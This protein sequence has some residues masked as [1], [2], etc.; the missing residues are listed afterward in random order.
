MQPL[1]HTG[2]LAVA[3]KSAAYSI[4]D[5]VVLNVNGGK[6]IHRIVAGSD[7]SG[8]RTKGDNRK[9]V[10]PWVAQTHQIYGKYWRGFTGVGAALAW[11][12]QRPYEFAGIL[13]LLAVLPYVPTRRRRL[14]AGLA[15]ALELSVKE[16]R[17]DGR[18]NAEYGVLALCALALAS[19][20]AFVGA[21][22]MRH[23]LFT[24]QGLVAAVALAWAGGFTVFFVYRLYDGVGVAEPA[25]SMYALSGRLHLV[26]CLPVLE[27]RSVGSAIELRTLA[28]KYR[29]PVLHRIDPETGVHSFLLITVQKGAFMWRAVPAFLPAPA[30]RRFHF[31]LAR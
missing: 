18:S 30:L 31:T 4:G 9:D 5:L 2:D 10:D 25:K 19:A 12:A 13:A 17:R 3:R 21:L 26:E 22:G 6:V 16:P 11:V 23:V 8:W 20:L 27:A 24:L 15:L 14:D 29:L 28:E 1:L 7:A